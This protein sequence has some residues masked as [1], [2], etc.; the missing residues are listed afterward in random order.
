M[1]FLSSRK[2]QQNLLLERAEQSFVANCCKTPENT[3]LE[4]LQIWY[5]F[6]LSGSFMHFWL[7]VVIV[8][9]VLGTK[10]YKFYNFI[11]I[12]MRSSF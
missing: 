8:T 4:N 1:Y 6:V 10:M 9:L 5:I 3:A 2:I 11:L 12:S 7:K